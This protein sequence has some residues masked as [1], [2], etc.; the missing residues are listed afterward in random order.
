MSASSTKVSYEQSCY[1]SGVE[2]FSPPLIKIGKKETT[3]TTPFPTLDLWRPLLIVALQLSLLKQLHTQ[4]HIQEVSTLVSLTIPIVVTLVYL[5]FVAWGLRRMKQVEQQNNNN[6]KKKKENQDHH[7]Q[8]PFS[9]L[10]VYSPESLRPWM[11]SYNVYQC[12]LNAFVALELCR[13][14]YLMNGTVWGNPLLPSTN[15]TG[16]RLSFL[17]MVHAQN[18]MIELSDTIFMI[19]RGKAAQVTSLHVWHH[20]LL[21]WS[22]YFVVRYA[23][24]GDAY[25]GA[26]VN[27][28]THVMIYLHY[29]LTTF[30]YTSSTWYK[31]YLTSLQMLQFVV[32]FLHAGYCLYH[33]NY[34]A[35]LCCLNLFVQCNMM[36]LFRSFY[37]RTYGE[38]NKAQTSPPAETIAETTAE[39][40]AEATAEIKIEKTA[41]KTA[42]IAAAAVCYSME[43]VARHNG[44]HEEN[45]LWCV[46]N[47]AVLDITEFVSEH[48]GGNVIVLAS[49]KFFQSLISNLSSIIYHLS[50]IIYHLSSI[51]YH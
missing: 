45:T 9:N 8:D 41:E 12:L 13:E 18:K 16:N 11:L 14:V 20:M 25:F 35:E 22:W 2:G 34:P 44:S 47:G 49:G 1:G 42:E 6:D 32:C 17:I 23:C 21:L 51:I 36:V 24:G 31:K 39:A 33:H 5:A 38:K 43:E 19:L 28:S 3:T 29:A 10:S 50:S 30:G 7:H 15:P 26:V 40:T 4:I 27:S 48:P 46:V 37:Q